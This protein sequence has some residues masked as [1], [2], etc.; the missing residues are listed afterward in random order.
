IAT[1][2]HP[3]LPK[4]EGVEYGIDSN[5]FFELS[6]IP[7]TTAVIGS[8]YIAVELA[9]V[10]NALGS[11]VGLFIRKDF[12]VRRFDQFLSETLVEVMQ[13]DGVKIHT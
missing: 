4:I 1:G 11:Q 10:L 3:L 8:G 7:K 9:G 6:A 5:G 12:P 2:T 13:A